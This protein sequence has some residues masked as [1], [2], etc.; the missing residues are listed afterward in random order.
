MAFKSQLIFA[1]LSNI[2]KEK[3]FKIYNEHISNDNEWQTVSKF[4]LLRYLSMCYNEKVR[5]IVLDNYLTL[6]RMPEKTL[7]KWLLIKIPQQK[8]GFIKYIK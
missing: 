1:V 4:V 3:S 8:T 5:E 7:Y 2:L 6:E